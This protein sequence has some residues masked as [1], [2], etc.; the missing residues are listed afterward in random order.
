MGITGY[1]PNS[2]FKRTSS[3]QRQRTQKSRRDRSE[4]RTRASVEPEIHRTDTQGWRD[5]S[6]GGEKR[7]MCSSSLRLFKERGNTCW[8]TPHYNK[9]MKW[10]SHGQRRVWE[11]DCRPPQEQH[12]GLLCRRVY[13]T[14][15]PPVQTHSQTNNDS[16]YQST[17]FKDTHT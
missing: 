2:H 17:V 6:A 13:S 7:I 16:I 10:A 11:K 3:V 14:T 5:G 4:G 9:H 15:T 1:N 8:T 12:N